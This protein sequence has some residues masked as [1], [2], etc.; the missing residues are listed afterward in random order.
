[1][2][3]FN[4]I[5][6]IILKN[7]AHNTKNEKYNYVEMAEWPHHIDGYELPQIVRLLKIANNKFYNY[8]KDDSHE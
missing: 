5:K 1:M 4:F 6:W 3:I 7:K 2:H 8:Y